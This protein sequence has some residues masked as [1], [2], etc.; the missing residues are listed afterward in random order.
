MTD[1][2]KKNFPN[3]PQRQRFLDELAEKAKHEV[4]FF[5]LVKKTPAVEKDSGKRCWQ[6]VQLTSELINKVLT[7]KRHEEDYDM[8]L[9]NEAEAHFVMLL[10]YEWNLSH[11][12]GAHEKLA[13]AF[14]GPEIHIWGNGPRIPHFNAGIYHN[15]DFVNVHL[16][17]E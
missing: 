15:K 5:D 16:F 14:H 13:E 12:N 6:I 9:Y 7:T 3:F 10:I 11:Y 4:K 1:D 17:F 2:F 8:I